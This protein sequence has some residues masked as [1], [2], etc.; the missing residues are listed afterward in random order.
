MK[1]IIGWSFTGVAILSWA[2]REWWNFHRKKELLLH[3]QEIKDICQ[4][5]ITKDD[6]WKGEYGDTHAKWQSFRSTIDAVIHTIN[7]MMMNINFNRG[8]GSQNHRK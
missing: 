1:E 5:A 3:I 6:H 4:S 8:G 7:N 2:I